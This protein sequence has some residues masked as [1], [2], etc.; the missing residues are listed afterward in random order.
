MNENASQS[1]SSPKAS[2]KQYWLW[3][4]LFF[5]IALGP[6]VYSRL[7]APGRRVQLLELKTA[8]SAPAFDDRLKI[9]TFNIAH[10][11]GTADGNW[12][13]PSQPKF[14]RIQAI[15]KQLNTINA[16]VVVLNE[17]DFSSTW[18]GH[19]NQAEA[20]AKAAGYPHRVEQ[21]NLD[22]RFLYGSFKF[23]NAILSRY[24]IVNAKVVNFPPENAWESWLVG[25]KR[26]AIAT[27]RLAEN[28]LIRIAA[29]H[30]EHRSES[31]RVAGAEKII[32]LLDPTGENVLIAAGDF[33]STP[34]GFP[35]S[36]QTSDGDNALQRLIDCDAFFCCPADPPSSEQLTFSTMSPK[37]VIDWILVSK[38]PPADQSIDP[39]NSFVSYEAI[40][41]DLSDHRPIVAEITLRAYPQP[42]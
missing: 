41:T 19:Q 8:T 26:G 27:V 2:R 11:R 15:A 22:F 13:E 25:C 20:I 9:V 29:V 6:Y 35:Q 4:L 39:P 5:I 34:T 28:Q 36:S 3:L 31:T 32:E 37:S 18:S 40:P 23:G 38:K 1:T 10:G 42:F 7:Q 16:D 12:S 30:L 21:R 24:P 14:D 17:V 33:N